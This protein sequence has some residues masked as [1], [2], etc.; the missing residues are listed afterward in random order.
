MHTNLVIQIHPI[1]LQFL[2]DPTE[3]KPTYESESSASEG[4]LPV[5]ELTKHNHELDRLRIGH[6]PNSEFVIR[7]IQKLLIDPEK[8]KN[9]S[10][11]YLHL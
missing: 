2:D 5:V 10:Y 3:S 6:C 11:L 8:S 7:R 4:E 1:F 9:P